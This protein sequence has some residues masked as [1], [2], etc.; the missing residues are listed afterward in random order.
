[1]LATATSGCAGLVAES[2]HVETATASYVFDEGP[3]GVLAAAQ[4]V[5]F[6]RGY[7]VRTATP[8]ALETHWQVSE[9][10][11]RRARHLVQATTTADGTRLNAMRATQTRD[12]DGRWQSI[13]GASR[14]PYFELAVIER[15]DPYRANGIRAEAAQAREA[16]KR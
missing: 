4:A 5:L 14:D 16:A 8:G 10:G 9:D 1:M 11:D 7:I 15:L 12:T 13:G 2:A 6:E 3:D